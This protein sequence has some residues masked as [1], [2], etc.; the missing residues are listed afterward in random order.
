MKYCNELPI[1]S[2]IDE[3]RIPNT[4]NVSLYVDSENKDEILSFLENHRKKFL[5]ILYVIISGIYNNE[6]YR[7]ETDNITA[8]KFTGKFSSNTR[9]YC[10]EFFQNGK[11]IVMITLLQKKV[12][13]N[14][15]DKVLQQRL[16]IIGGYEYEFNGKN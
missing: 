16:K 13:K 2:Y 9:I 1:K 7:K 12:Q 15:E 14:Q 5:R 8:M 11:K 10:K 4:K 3:L 6:L